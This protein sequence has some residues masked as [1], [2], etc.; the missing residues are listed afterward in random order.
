VVGESCE[1]RNRHGP[2]FGLRSHEEGIRG[3]AGG[4]GGARRGRRRLVALAGDGTR[5]FRNGDLELAP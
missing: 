4:G 1:K 3:G 2:K 5:E